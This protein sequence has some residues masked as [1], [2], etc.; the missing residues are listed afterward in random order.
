[1]LLG[2]FDYEDNLDGMGFSLSDLQLSPV[3]VLTPRQRRT[4]LKAV[5][6]SIWTKPTGKRWQLMTHKE[7]VASVLRHGAG[8]GA[9]RSELVEL[10]INPRKC[11][12]E[13]PR[14]LWRQV[15]APQSSYTESPRA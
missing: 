6:H 15:E 14:W 4:F 3:I 12:R 7:W 9:M 8:S 2:S 11:A 13:S 10:S 5:G 1:M